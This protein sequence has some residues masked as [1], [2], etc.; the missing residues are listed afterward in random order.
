MRTS[1]SRRLSK[2]CWNSGR[3]ILP[4][5]VSGWIRMQTGP[6]RLSRGRARAKVEKERVA[7]GARAREAK[8]RAAVGSRERAAEVLT[9]V[10]V[11]ARRIRGGLRVTGAEGRMGGQG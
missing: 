3:Q 11:C 4:P 1:G 5:L 7:E 2:D 8:E 6:T 9:V 10:V